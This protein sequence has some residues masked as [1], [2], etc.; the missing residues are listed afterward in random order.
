[1]SPSLASPKDRPNADV[2]L[3]DGHCRICIGQVERLARWDS[4][5]RLAFLSLHDPQVAERYP[6]LPHDYLLKN[7][8]V[9]GSNGQRYAGADAFRRLSHQMPRLWWMAAL[10]HI[11]FSMPLWRWLYGQIAKRRY[12]IGGKVECADGACAVHFGK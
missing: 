6:D 1:M 9:V 12:L 4:R 2:V 5:G 10:M 3:Y 11:P 7:M 8:V